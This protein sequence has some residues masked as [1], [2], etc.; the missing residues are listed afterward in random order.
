MPEEITPEIR[1]KLNELLASSAEYLLYTEEELLEIL[2]KKESQLKETA[3][4]DMFEELYYATRSGKISPEEFKKRLRD[5]F[6]SESGKTAL[7]KMGKIVTQEEAQAILGKDKVL[8]Y[9]ESCDAWDIPTTYAT[10]D[11]LINYSSDNLIACAAK[12]KSGEADWRLV[13]LHGLSMREQRSAKSPEYFVYFDTSFDY[14]L[15]DPDYPNV[16]ADHKVPSGFYLINFK[17]ANVRDIKADGYLKN[18]QSVGIAYAEQVLE[19]VIA[20]KLSR[21]KLIYADKDKVGCSDYV[22]LGW[23]GFGLGEATL[24]L[25]LNGQ[26]T[27]ESFM[28]FKD[29][30]FKPRA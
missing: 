10:D 11:Y 26:E 22:S 5:I 20:F 27:F 21:N 7:I 14:Y 8:T 3:K 15:D 1:D 12:N 19:S 18:D 24:F 17:V 16:A 6:L 29:W 4:M 30:D 2:R 13:Y 25:Y 28:T 9:E 23:S